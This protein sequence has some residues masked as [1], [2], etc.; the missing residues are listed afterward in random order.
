MNRNDFL[1]LLERPLRETV[2]TIDENQFRLRGM[3]E[4]EGT[5]YEL[6]LQDK[7]GNIKYENARRALIAIMLI[8]DDGNRIVTH[9]SELRRL[10]RSI[11]GVLYDE[12]QKLNRYKPGEIK[13]IEKNSDGADD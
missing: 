3:T 4:E 11:A 10:P 12:C 1:A 7:Q 13:D 9:E 8:D 2:V 5:E 6:S